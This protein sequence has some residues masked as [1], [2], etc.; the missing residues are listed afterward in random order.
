MHVHT[1]ISDGTD[2]P[3]Q[4]VERGLNIG[5]TAIA[6]TDHDIIA[7]ALEA[8]QGAV[9]KNIEVIVGV[10]ISCY[11]DEAEVHVLGYF[12]Q[13][14]DSALTRK[15]AKMQAVRL[16][17]AQII[18]DKLNKMGIAITWDEV[19][20]L[21]G[22]GT[23]GRPHIADAMVAQG[24]ISNRELAFKK[25]LGYGGPAYATRK[26]ITPTEAIQLICDANGVAVLAHPGTIRTSY[27]IETMVASGLKGIEVWHPH[28][29]QLQT[30]HY[31]MLSRQ[32]NLIPTGGSD[33]HGVKHATCNKLGAVTAPPE[34]L[35]RIK[36]TISKYC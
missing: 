17:R 26:K 35:D 11:L 27:S 25:Y 19:Q 20:A 13:I 3:Q 10:E 1:T 8:K 33:Y 9:G 15:L 29:N 5:L 24:Y 7:G 2:T 22:E 28:H 36:E 16:E 31:L 34:S 21:A 4:V 23:V 12:D 6:I 18:I 30:N 32:L 14:K